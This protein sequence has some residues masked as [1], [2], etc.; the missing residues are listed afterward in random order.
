MALENKNKKIVQLLLNNKSIDI[1]IELSCYSFYFHK[2]VGNAGE[3][4]TDACKPPTGYVKE[5]G[6][7]K[8]EKEENTLTYHMIAEKNGLINLFK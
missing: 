4:I 1:N 8:S 5:E 3:K 7:L 6:C 2:L